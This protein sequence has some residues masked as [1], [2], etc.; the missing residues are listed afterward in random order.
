[1]EPKD[2]P[3]ALVRFLNLTFTCH[4]IAKVRNTMKNLLAFL[5]LVVVPG[6][7]LAADPPLAWPQFRGP[8]G[9]GIA[10]KQKPPLEV[11]PD[12]N[13]VWKVATPSG[14]SSPIIV[15][16]K[17]ILTAFED[18]K[19]YTIAYA[20]ADGKELWRAHAPA[21]K[22]EAYQKTEGSPAASTPATDGKHIVSYF[23]SCGLFCYDLAGKEL[24]KHPLPMAVTLAD[25]GTGTSPIVADGLV[26]LVRDE[27]KNPLILALDVTNGALKWEKKR[28][29]IAGY[30][31]PVLWNTPGGKQIVAGGYG[32][33]IGYDLRTGE[34]KWSVTG[35]P[36]AACTTPIVADGNL[37]F[38]GWSPGDA[39]DKDFKMPTFDALLKQA[40]EEKQGYLT[41]KG[42]EKTMLRGFFDNNDTNKDGKITREEWDASIKLMSIGKN[43]VF[44]LKPG[45]SG[46]VT[47]THVL[48]KKTKGLPYVPSGL[49]YK[50]QYV[51]VKDGGFLTAYDARTGREVYVQERAVAPGRYYASLVAANGYIYSTS[52]ENGAITVLKA[53]TAK[54]EVV[55]RNPGLGERTRA[56]PA[57]VDNV[58]YVRTAGHLYAFGDKK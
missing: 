25:F 52:L 6:V 28:Q 47:H 18:G 56:T 58:L 19:L 44:A 2:R 41:R 7:G 27:K 46:D 22:I 3:Q 10:D 12:K 35:M 36:A 37:F 8:G 30:G 9:T 16:D 21:D 40:G 50:G 23:G 57:I 55:A 39:A 32:R 13:V 38:A 51:L 11:G 54:P 48:W 1:M 53:G 43:S 4:E 49:V 15:G 20:R 17:V 45:G 34:E 42:S 31:T 26:I 14:A 24:W 5:S 29:S 33:M